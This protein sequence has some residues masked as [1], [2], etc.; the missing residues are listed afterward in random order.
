MTKKEELKKPIIKESQQGKEFENL[1]SIIDEDVVKKIGC[2]AKENYQHDLHTIR[3]LIKERTEWNKQFDLF[4]TEKNYPWKGASNVTLPVITTACINTQARLMSLV[5]GRQPVL[6]AT[7]GLSVEDI[8]KAERVSRHMQYQL[9]KGIPEFMSGHDIAM[10]MLP[11]D[12]SVF[13]KTFYDSLKGRIVSDYVK[14]DNIVINYF[15]RRMEDCRRWSQKTY[16]TTSQLLE[17]G[18]QGVFLNVEK[19]AVEGDIQPM[20]EQNENEAYKDSA[21]KISQ[22]TPDEATPRLVIEQHTYLDLSKSGIEE[23]VIIIFD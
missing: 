2:R 8:E 13:K 19:V 21:N 1:V 5:E 14:A 3:P 20:V 11:R 6:A 9:Q 18:E 15:T 23:P 16:Y 7:V 10:L 17:K 22:S 4:F 12:G